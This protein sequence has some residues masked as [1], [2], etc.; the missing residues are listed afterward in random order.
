[1]VSTYWAIAPYDSDIPDVF[2]RAWSHHLGQ[3]VIAIGWSELGDL[4]G[5]RRTD[6]EERAHQE[7][8]GE[9]GAVR[10]LW[11]FLHEI[12]VGDVVVARRGV[13]RV[14]GIGRVTR[15]AYFDEA[16]GNRRTGFP[17]PWT[18][19]NF[20]GVEW[21]TVK[22]FEFQHVVFTRMTVSRIGKHLDLIKSLME[23]DYN[24]SA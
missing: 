24:R 14:I 20:L 18:T 5:L 12:D 21:L 13:K 22:E 11:P 1:M 3:N 9:P 17:R 10:S 2:Q 8:P 6:L 23:A 15:P 4:S 7:W 19:P 16:A